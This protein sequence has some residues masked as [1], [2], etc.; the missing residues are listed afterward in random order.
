MNKF[1]AAEGY[2]THSYEIKVNSP[3]TEPITITNSMFN[4]GMLE[5]RRGRYPEALKWFREVLDTRRAYLGEDHPLVADT[6]QSIGTTYYLQNNY[7]EAQKY[8]RQ[9]A[10]IFKKKLCRLENIVDDGALR[11]GVIDRY[12]T[13]QIQYSLPR[14]I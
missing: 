5:L 1:D 7:A 14:I 12:L 8:S 2:L 4:L 13:V 10:E 6:L 3:E 9:A 11:G